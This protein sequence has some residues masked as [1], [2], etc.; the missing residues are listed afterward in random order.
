MTSV[1]SREDT[2]TTTTDEWDV[3]DDGWGRRAV[4]FATLSEPGSCREFVTLHHR[5]DISLGERL[6]D[7]S[8]GSGLALEL[9]R[10][11]GAECAGIE[12]SHRLVA[13]ARDRNPDS[14]LRV[15]D[16]H[17]LP[18]DDESFDVA[19]SF[20]GIWASTPS[21]IR[22]VHRVLV[23]GGRV[24]LTTWGQ[25]RRSPGTWAYTPFRI[26]DVGPFEHEASLELGTPGAGEE[27]LTRHGFVDV[28]RFDVPMVWEFA[29]PYTY[30]RTLAST[31]PA[32]EAIESIG[33]TAFI[34]AAIHQA[35]KLVRD[36]LPLRAP[37]DVVGYV[38][39]KPF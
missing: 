32:Y 10:V 28:E 14:D 21:A 27:F 13:I 38:A 37:I 3:A 1:I 11:R 30:A 33:E 17:A 4:D 26:A 5:L 12:A 6:L 35:Q 18:W 36:G 2:R 19:T 29:D 16:G 22:E 20:R 7:V 23:R 9:A 8:C 34:E 15:G 25:L 24:G 39:R 31:G